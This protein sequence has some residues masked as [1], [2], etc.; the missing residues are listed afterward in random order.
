MATAVS[1]G[2]GYS[3]DPNWCFDSGATDHI[4]NDL[5]HLTTGDH[6][7]GGDQIQVANGAGLSISHIGH[8]SIAGLDRP[9]YL[10]HVLYAPQINRHLISVQKPASDN[11]AYVEFHANFFLVKD[12][13]TKA[14]LLRGKCRNGLYM[15]PNNQLKN[16]LLSA[17]VTQEQWHRRLGH[18]AAPVTLRILQ[19]NKI[20]VALDDSLSSIC[21]A[22]Q[23]GKAH[24]LPFSPSVHVTTARLQL[25][26]TDV[27][28]PA[29]PSVNNSKYYVSFIDDYS[30]HV[31]IYFLKYKSDVEPIF[32]QFQKHVENSL[33]HRIKTI[34]SDWGG[35]YHKLHKYFQNTGITH[36]ISCPHTHTSK[37]E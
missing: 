8:S 4:T 5:Q 13:T 30:R 18:P 25:I 28:G 12:T 9:L 24:Q 37:M 11:N 35:E 6:S 1:S 17:K 10:N 36:R 22:C 27:W 19:K 2:G 3:V 33:G 31:W 32:L 16:A 20:V 7:N 29:I 26:H 14:I 21:N 34:Q 15:L 23:Q